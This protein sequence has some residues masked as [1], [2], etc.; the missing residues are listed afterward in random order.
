MEMTHSTVDRWYSHSQ[1]PFALPLRACVRT[2]TV[3]LISYLWTCFEMYTQS[4]HLIGSLGNDV[5][6]GGHGDDVIFGYIPGQQ[7]SADDD[8]DDDND[9]DNAVANNDRDVI[10]AGK[11]DDCITAGPGDDIIYAGAGETRETERRK[12]RGKESNKQT[13]LAA[14]LERRC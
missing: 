13:W 11:G 5:I 8:D 1:A 4:D 12:K 9:D 2:H 6:F 3:S 14:T 7:A 10:V